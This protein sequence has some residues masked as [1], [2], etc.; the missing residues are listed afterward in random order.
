MKRWRRGRKPECGRPSAEV[1]GAQRAPA[2]CP[3]MAN[4]LS[5]P[6]A[7]E[8]NLIQ[9]FFQVQPRNAERQV[10][11]YQL[12]RGACRTLTEPSR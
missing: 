10:W 7:T 4:G 11:I 5:D 9:P 2:L 12:A 3:M 8:V 6:G 1:V